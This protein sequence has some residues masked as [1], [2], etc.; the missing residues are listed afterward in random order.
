M[1][2]KLNDLRQRLITAMQEKNL[3]IDKIKIIYPQISDKRKEVNE[4]MVKSKLV[5]EEET[6]N[7][8]ENPDETMNELPA[9]FNID[10]DETVAKLN[11]ILKTTSIK[12]KLDKAIKN[13]T[14]NGK[15]F[16]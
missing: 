9:P 12:S 4:L 5:N 16:N 14:R 10:A 1:V 2:N 6:T 7:Q 15:I 13:S 8:K 11:D 3:I